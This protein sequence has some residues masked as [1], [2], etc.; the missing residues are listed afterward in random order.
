MLYVIAIALRISRHPAI[1]NENEAVPQM[2]TQPH[3]MHVEAALFT[4]G[5]SKYVAVF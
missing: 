2:L 3:P 5:S 1:T 4:R